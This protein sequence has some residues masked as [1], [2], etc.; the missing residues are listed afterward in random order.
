M[1]ER[2]SEYIGNFND[3]E[4]LEGWT[5]VCVCVCVD[6]VCYSESDRENNCESEIHM[7]VCVCVDSVCDS[8]SDITKQ[9]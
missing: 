1:R 9:K 3:S 7:C 6:S 4:A 5:C 8:E 2:E